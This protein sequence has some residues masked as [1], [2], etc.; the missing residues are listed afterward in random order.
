MPT[1]PVASVVAPAELASALKQAWREGAPPDAAGALRDHPNLLNHRSLVLDLAYEEYS[2]REEAGSIPDVESFCRDLPAFRS[3]VRAMI[4]D[5][6]ALIDHPELFELLEFRWPAA[7]EVFAG[8]VVGREL[9]RGAFARVYL[10]EDPDTGRPV[11]LKLSPAASTEARTLGP[12]RHPHVAE[13]YWARRVGGASA[14]CMPYVG[15]ATLWDVVAAAFDSPTGRAPT[16]RTVLEAIDKVGA[17]LPTPEPVAPLLRPGEAYADAIVAIGSR[18]AG[19]LAVLHARGI[20]HGDLKPSNIVLGP[21]GHPYLID[22]NLAGGDDEL[23]RYG[24]TLP[25]MAPERVQRLLRESPND[26]ISSDRPDVYSFGVVLFEALTGRVPF[27]P[28][29]PSDI[30]VAAANLQRQM[31]AGPPRLAA[32]GVPGSL[33]RLV[34][35]CLEPDPLRRPSASEVHRRLQGILHRRTRWGRIF[36]VAVGIAASAVVGSYSV[37]SG[38]I[39]PNASNAAPPIIGT[40]HIAAGLRFADEGDNERAFSEFTTAFQ[41]HPDGR[42]LALMGYSRT[43]AGKHEQAVGFYWQALTELKYRQPWVHNNRAYGMIQLALNKPN[44]LGSAI[45]E[46][47]A[48]L[49]LDPML[50]P[51]HF[52]RACGRFFQRLNRDDWTLTDPDVVSAIQS[53]LDPILSGPGTPD[54][55]FL[56]AQVL[57]ASGARNSLQ[58]EQAVICLQKAVSLGYPPSSLKFDPV[59][60]KW[61]GNRDDFRAIL[62]LPPSSPPAV[63]VNLALAK[64]PAE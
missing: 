35:D 36:L 54:L 30:R 37:R 61:L 19:A 22:F 59:F 8:F 60:S 14:I 20:T 1:P 41:L 13:V 23:H 40:D 33:A 55:Y 6:R 56:A 4:R 43:R 26:G 32:L 58:L 38:I 52:N 62:R 45:A 21:G 46:A 28:G 47:E 10:A 5:Y 27:E 11:V 7:G 42:S 49:A 12:V 25:Y 44:E 53:D 18:L 50:Q 29:H 24:G 17:A 31:Q 16:S 51:A 15:G 3:D 2:L 39:H 63:L 64:P 57:T 34:R 48:A 9:G